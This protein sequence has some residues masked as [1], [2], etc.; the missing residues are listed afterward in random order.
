MKFWL[1]RLVQYER[2]AYIDS[3]VLVLRDVDAM[4]RCGAFCAA[5]IGPC[6]FNAGVFV[7]KPSLAV[8][9]DLVRRVDELDSFDGGDQG[10][11]NE[12]FSA[13]V[14]RPLFAP[15]PNRT[16]AVDDDMLR[17]PSEYNV[18]HAYYYERM[19]WRPRCLEPRLLHFPGAGFK[20]WHWY[21][22][23][24]L[25]ELH[26]L[27]QRERA[28]LP[29]HMQQQHYAFG[30]CVLAPTPP[31][32]LLASR[33]LGRQRWRRCGGKW[34]VSLLRVQ[35]LALLSFGVA[36]FAPFLF[37]RPTFTPLFGWAL[38]LEWHFVLVNLCMAAGA[39]LFTATTTTMPMYSLLWKCMFATAP[40]V[41]LEAGFLYA[42]T[43]PDIASSLHR[44]IAL[45]VVGIGVAA[46]LHLAIYMHVIVWQQQQ[47]QQ[48]RRKEDIERET[49][50]DSTSDDDS[51]D[52]R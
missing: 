25:T 37:F 45:V 16:R 52:S 18:H 4:L 26:R 24:V 21:S 8:Y 50:I 29:P 2:V 35:A 36:F 38:F 34:E 14:T 23:P 48:R 12:Y 27:W 5:L 15:D 20:P 17:L 42:L 31:L 1:W 11:L 28:T 47:Q 41:P 40:L 46:L 22:Y 10:F 51:I 7:A 13:L 6:H 39:S 49:S 3:D 44:K 9:D 43:F 33:Y 19:A 30:M 32:L